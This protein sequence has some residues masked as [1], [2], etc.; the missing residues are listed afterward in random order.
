MRG[1]GHLPLQGGVERRSYAC[2]YLPCTWAHCAHDSG[3]CHRRP[4]RGEQEPWAW[5]GGQPRGAFLVE[6]PTQ[7]DRGQ[8]AEC[9]QGTLP[10]TPVVSATR[11][12][13]S[14]R[15][16]MVSYPRLHSALGRADGQRGQPLPAR[17]LRAAGLRRALSRPTAALQLHGCPARG[18]SRA[19]RRPPARNPGRAR[20]L[21]ERYQSH[22]R[23]QLRAARAALHRC[24]RTGHPVI[25][26]Q[27]AVRALR[28]CRRIEHIV[29]DLTDRDLQAAFLASGAVAAGRERHS[30]AAPPASREG[31]NGVW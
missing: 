15:N 7:P 11:R 30:P 16:D 21:S 8:L 19:R 22:P 4:Q 6:L 13:R 10:A 28:R 17:A 9:Q 31:R 29:A 14:R 26:S 1:T 18:R 2:P 20:F 24:P 27:Y 25:N 3:D 23:L 5:R 12:Q